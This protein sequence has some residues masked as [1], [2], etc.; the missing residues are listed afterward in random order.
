[1][2]FDLRLQTDT[3]AFG[4]ED[5]AATS[6]IEVARILRKVADMVL[7]GETARPVFDINGNRVGSFKLD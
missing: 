3:A 7:D 5:D 4:D 6:A 2:A 1:M